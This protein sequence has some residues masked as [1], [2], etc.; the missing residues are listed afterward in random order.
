MSCEC[1][2]MFDS[3]KF[4]SNQNW[5]NDKCQCECKNPEK[6]S[7]VQNDYILESLYM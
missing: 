5:N 4:N 3:N 7:C 2:G 6:T 1:E